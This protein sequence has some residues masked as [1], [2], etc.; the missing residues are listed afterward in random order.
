MM[1]MDNP[2]DAPVSLHVSRSSDSSWTEASVPT[3]EP[4]P[5][6]KWLEVGAVLAIGILPNLSNAM[7]AEPIALPS[8][9]PPVWRACVSNIAYSTCTIYVVLYL[10]ARSGDSWE[11]F[12]L[13]RPR[14]LDLV[15]GLVLFLVGL[16]L[17]QIYP[18]FRSLDDGPP[19]LQ[20]Y[21]NVRRIDLPLVALTFTISALSEELVTRSYLI[22]RLEE[23]LNSRVQGTVIAALAFASYHIY[24]GFFGLGAAFVFGLVYGAAFLFIRRVWP[25]ILGHALI[26]SFVVWLTMPVA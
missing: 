1:P 8:A 17:W 4:R 23:L 22:T 3:Q 21:N 10:I 12:G 26:N 9:L 18:A 19:G 13:L 20:W 25:L 15:I 7:L 16:E 2:A 24:Q 5:P 14:K 11:Q 6:N